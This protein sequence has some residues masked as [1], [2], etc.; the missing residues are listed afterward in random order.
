MNL[1][2]CTIIKDEGRFLEEWIEFHLLQ[3][4]DKFYLYDNGSSDNTAEVLAPYVNQ[5]IV[6][7]VAW[8]GE[9]KQPAMCE[10][11]ISVF[12]GVDKWCAFID[13]DEFLWILDSSVFRGL[14]AYGGVCVNWK[15]MGSNGHVKRPEGLVLE[16]YRKGQKGVNQHVKTILNMRYAI[17]RGR[18]VHSFRSSRPIVNL[19][20]EIQPINYALSEN[21][22]DGNS[23]QLF[24]FHVKSQ[25]DYRFKC[26][27]NRADV[28]QKRNFEESFAAHDINDKD[29]AMDE[30]AKLI[31]DTLKNRRNEQ[32]E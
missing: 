5:G 31:K 14:K 13:V 24:H 12:K 6:E 8:P 18:D 19:R 2:I 27:R 10:N 30:F 16:N 20:M 28:P 17:G 25:E 21:P 3:G 26:S 4:V 1:E 29:Y 15:L 32:G 23:L 9:S 11:Y 22:V 7:L